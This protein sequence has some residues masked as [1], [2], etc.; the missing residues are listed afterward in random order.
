[1]KKNILILWLFITSFWVAAQPEW[2]WVQTAKLSTVSKITHSTTDAAGNVYVT[3]FFEG[4]ML[5]GNENLDCQG[6]LDAF[7]AKYSPEGQLL[8]AKSMNGTGYNYA[9]QILIDEQQN[10]YVAG[11]FTQSVQIENRTLNSRGDSDIFLAKYNPQGKLLWVKQ[12]GGNDADAPYGIGKDKQGNIYL[13]GDFGRTATFGSFSLKSIG[14]N[15]IFLAKYNENGDCLW[16]KRSG[17]TGEDQPKSM[18]ADAAGNCYVVGYTYSPTL[19]FGT[20]TLKN[21]GDVDAFLV[22][23]NANG[24]TVWAKNAGG[25][26]SDEA[27]GTAL[28]SE[29]NIY[30]TGFFKE[31]AQFDGMSLAANSPSSDVFI[32][33]YN[34]NGQIEWAKNAGSAIG[35]EGSAIAIDAADNIY[36]TG[37]FSGAAAFDEHKINSAGGQDIFLAKYNT[38]GNC[39]AVYSIGGTSTEEGQTLTNHQNN[40]FLGGYFKSK[41]VTFSQPIANDAGNTLFFIGKW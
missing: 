7:W 32:A 20:Q 36:V 10:I 37:W 5:L 33:K 35:D 39:T 8:M 22:K 17:G 34:P 30:I 13:T 29:G 27:R 21:Y 14:Y 31:K 2:K 9:N 4:T 18:V 26:K 40:M 12:E 11:R 19:S 25:T 23:F 38:K 3:G 1:M 24:E 6:G 41:K 16:A 15:D 28:D